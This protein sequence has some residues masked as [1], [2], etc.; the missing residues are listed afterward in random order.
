MGQGAQVLKKSLFERKI[1]V[2]CFK[3]TPSCN[4]ESSL[5]LLFYNRLN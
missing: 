4:S 3:V 1:Q 5:N 2:R